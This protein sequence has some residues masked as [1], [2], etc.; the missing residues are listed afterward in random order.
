MPLLLLLA[1][2]TTVHAHGNI[3]WSDEYIGGLLHPLT[4]PAHVLI[5]LGLG[6]WLGQHQPL[7]LKTP[8]IILA[9][10]SAF[11]L[12][13]T[14]IGRIESVYPPILTCI[15]LGIGTFIAWQK[16]LPAP[17]A[18]AVFAAAALAIGC[19]SGFESES[20]RAVFKSLLGT[21]LAMNLFVVVVAIHTETFAKREW[22]K[23]G[24]RVLGSWIIAISFLVLAFSLRKR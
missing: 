16:Q 17:A 15:A 13:F 1:G 2:P 24:V 18:N 19:D 4:N 8:M 5:L 3:K 6:L 21:W 10:F 11:A 22:Q 23:I 20:A 12:V 9:S 14:V 7:K